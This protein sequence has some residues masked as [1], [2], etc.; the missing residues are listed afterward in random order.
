MDTEFHFHTTPF[1]HQ[2]DEF[3]HSRDRKNYA[4]LWEQGTGKSKLLLDQVA[5]LYDQEE[6]DGVL[7]VAPNGV[8]RNWIVDQ[9]PEHWDAEE[10]PIRTFLW[11]AS[12][13]GTQASRREF[14][15]MLVFPGLAFFAI[16][17]DALNT[18]KGYAAC[19]KFL[20]THQAVMVLDESHRIKTPGAKRTK[21]ALKL[22]AFAKYKRILTGTVVGNSPFDVY[23]QFGFLDPKVLG[24]NSFFTFKNRY[25]VFEQRFAGTHKYQKLLRY[26]NVEE[27]QGLIAH[28]SSRVTKDDVL[29]LPP[30]LYQK[31]YFQM[32][33]EQARLYENLREEFIVELKNGL[34]LT[35]SLA[36]VRMLR[37]Q[38]ITCGYLPIEGETQ[39]I[40]DTNPRL[41]ALLDLLEDYEDQKVIIFARFTEDIRQIEAA[42]PQGSCVSYYGDTD[43]EAREAAKDRLKNDPSCRYFVANP[44]T[45]SEGL[46]LFAASVV[47]YYSNSFKLLE[48]LQSEDRIHRIGQTRNCTYIDLVA[49]DTV[50]DRI[51]AALREKKNIAAMINGDTLGEWI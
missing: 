24:H 11:S 26:R 8:H 16:N 5:W 9:I 12:R 1:K 4:I 37:L 6:V 23:S 13:A 7:L 14:D 39:A 36:L 47:V 35:A 49:P 34:T 3:F 46:N 41:L 28:H 21:K 27:L 45:A 29:D 32:S 17:Y 22:G 20:K 31:R 51:V 10:R 33:P 18:D 48:R 43:D 25:G 2:R 40:A 42:L 38:Q 30:K 19:E 50:D 15:E 44:Q